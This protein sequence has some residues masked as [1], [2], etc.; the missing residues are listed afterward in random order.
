MRDKYRVQIVRESYTPPAAARGGRAAY[1][2]APQR[3]FG[4]SPTTQERVRP[5]FSGR[6]DLLGGF[7]C[8]LVLRFLSFF[9]FSGFVQF[10]LKNVLDLELLQI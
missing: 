8:F 4:P 3:A 1:L 7:Y 9:G 2:F 6:F 5:I 10:F